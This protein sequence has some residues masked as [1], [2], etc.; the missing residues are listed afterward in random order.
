MSHDDEF[1]WLPAHG[2]VLSKEDLVQV[3]EDLRALIDGTAPFD[4]NRSH[5]VDI[6]V[7]ITRAL[8][9]GEGR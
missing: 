8:E 1:D 2:V 9:R 6:A 7:V 4:A 5:A 3:F